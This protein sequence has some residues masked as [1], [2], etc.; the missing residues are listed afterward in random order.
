MEAKKTTLT[1]EE[2]KVIYGALRSVLNDKMSIPDIRNAAAAAGIDVTRIP[3]RS[4]ARGGSGSR[5]EVMPAIDSLFAEKTLDDQVRTLAILG[6]R[7]VT[8][9]AEVAEKVR[10]ILGKHGYQFV[11]GTFVPVGMLDAREARYLPSTSASELARA[12][13]RLVEGDESGAITAACGA[14][15]LATQSIYENHGLGDPGKVSFSAKVN[16][17]LQRLQV[18]EEMQRDFEELGI[19]TDDAASIVKEIAQATNHAAQ[20]L[21]IVRKCMGDVHGTKP[22]LR[23]TAYDTIKWASAIC[24]L[25][26]GKA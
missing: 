9:S 11:D 7:L 10:G 13:S 3:A 19:L 26:E 22:A 12:T 8:R 17:S 18:F 6:E 23:K 15:D 14:I 25:L 24:G 5:A 1:D 20:A 21:Q 16:T 2:V 4:E